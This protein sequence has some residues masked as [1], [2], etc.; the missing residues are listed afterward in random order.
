MAGESCAY[1]VDACHAIIERR[2]RDRFLKCRH[3]VLRPGIPNEFVA[4]E[5]VR[6]V[7]EPPLPA[8]LPTVFPPLPSAPPCTPASKT[9]YSG[10]SQKR[11][12]RD[13]TRPAPRH[14]RPPTARQ[15]ARTTAV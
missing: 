7:F 1:I 12:K 3:G 10:P 14:R 9:A 11:T 5:S 2:G 8:F 13:R 15:S 6:P 4:Q